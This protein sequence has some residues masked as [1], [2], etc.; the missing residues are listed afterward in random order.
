MSYLPRPSRHVFR[1]RSES[2][3]NTPLNES[4]IALKPIMEKFKKSNNLDIT[5]LVIVHDGDADDLGYYHK[6]LDPTDIHGRNY[7]WY[8]TIS[9]NVFLQD[10]K[11]KFQSRVRENLNEVLLK[12]FSETTGSKIFGFYIVPPNLSRAIYS[13]YRDEKG[14]RLMFNDIKVYDQKKELM[15]KFRKDKFLVSKN[16][17]FSSFF[18]IHGGDDLLTEEESIEIDG[19]ITSSKLKNAFMRYNKNKQINRVLVSKFIEGIAS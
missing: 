18:F 8:N 9:E 3:S 14:N 4:I 12:W 11:S 5:N 15:K 7:H 16:P 2:L 1:P 6:D 13:K 10:K 19:K 17:G